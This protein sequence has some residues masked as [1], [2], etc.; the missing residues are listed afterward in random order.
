M[1]LSGFRLTAT[2]LCRPLMA[3]GCGVLLLIAG[4]SAQTPAPTAPA[5][6]PAAATPPT[7][8]PSAAAPAAGGATADPVV[9]KVDGQPVY[10]SDLQSAAQEIPPNARN[11]PQA[12][13]YPMLLEQMIDGQ[14]LVVEARKAGLQN[15][16][17]VKRQIA[18]ATDHVLETAMLS[19]IIGPTLTDDALHARYQRDIANQPGADEVH[20]RHILVDTEDLAKKIIADLKGGADFAALAKQ[21]SKDPGADHSGDLGF[22]RKDE[23]VPEFAAAAFA[24]QPGQVS[25]APVHTQFGWH[26]IQVLERKHSPPPTFDQ[27]RNDLRQKMVQEGIQSALA[28]A[29]AH[30]TV[31]KFNLD[32]SVP[33]ATDTAEPPP[34]PKP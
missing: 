28:D 7:A 14:A 22:F 19:K 9:A 29:R 13:L 8:A 20:A 23:M 5:T 25:D 26:V 1:L 16:P 32:G 10:L 31:E 21:Y 2:R 3:G 27:A 11:M 6:P 34:T 24:M 33:R 12:T 17:A 4:V 30:V 15:D 18:A